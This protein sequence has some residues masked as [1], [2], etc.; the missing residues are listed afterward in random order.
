MSLAWED[1]D[2]LFADGF[3]TREIEAFHLATDKSGNLQPL[4]NVESPIWQAV[5]QERKDLVVNVIQKFYSTEGWL[6]TRNIVDQILDA[7]GPKDPFDWLKKLYQPKGRVPTDDIATR[8]QMAAEERTSPLRA[9][10]D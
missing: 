8:V 10:L 2:S 4:A 1:I 6:P 5:R 3:T 7:F 9:W